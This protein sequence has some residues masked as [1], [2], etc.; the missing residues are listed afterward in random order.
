[1]KVDQI[2]FIRVIENLFHHQ[3]MMCN[4][5]DAIGI[6]PKRLLA[7]GNQP[8]VGYRVAAGKQGDVMPE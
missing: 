3:S 6:E 7:R 8:R 2:E 4:R 1:V 5:I